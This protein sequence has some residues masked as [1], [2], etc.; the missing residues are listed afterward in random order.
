MAT[1]SPSPWRLRQMRNPQLNRNGELTHLLTLDGLPKDIVTHILDTA[2]TFVPLAERDVKKVPLL[3]RSSGTFLTSRSARGT[4]VS[5]VSRIWV[6]MSLGSPSSVSRWVSSPLRL[7][8]GLRICRSLQ[9]DGEPVAI[10]GQVDTGVG[11]H[12]DTSGAQGCG[13][14]QLASAAIDQY[15]KLDRCRTAIIEELVHGATDGAA[16]VQ[17]VVDQDEML[18]IHIEGDVGGK[19][20]MVQAD[21]IEVI[22]IEADVQR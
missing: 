1:G 5:A 16:G 11:R 14:R 18:A 21:T 2:E 22:A 17:N 13:D 4:K 20:L 3:P 6:T 9:G 19:H 7:S 10:T 12:V 8:W 15:G